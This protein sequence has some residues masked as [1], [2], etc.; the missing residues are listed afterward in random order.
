M[1]GFSLGATIVHKFSATLFKRHT[2]AA[3]GIIPQKYDVFYCA[4]KKYS[5]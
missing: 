5:L 1:S 4:A 3:Y 2:F